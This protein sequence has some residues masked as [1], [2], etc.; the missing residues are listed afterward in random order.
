M[1]AQ[2]VSVEQPFPVRLRVQ[3]RVDAP[4]RRLHLCAP[5]AAATPPPDSEGVPVV[6]QVLAH[7]PP[8]LCLACIMLHLLS[9]SHVWGFSILHG[10]DGLPVVLQV[11]A[12]WRCLVACISTA[13]CLVAEPC[14][15]GYSAGTKWL[16]GCAMPRFQQ[17][18][19]SVIIRP[20]L[21]KD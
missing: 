15:C 16:T 12:P 19:R 4:L 14:I 5:V 17:V 21:R 11:L 20:G 6:L 8:S 7:N 18:R 1:R 10:S 13:I 9:G 3:S 2:S